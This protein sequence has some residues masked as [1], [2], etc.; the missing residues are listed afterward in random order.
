MICPECGAIAEYN[1]Y[2]GRTTCTR[3]AWESE[4]I[5]PFPS[6]TS[7]SVKKAKKD[8]YP[9]GERTFEAVKEG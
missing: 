5:K 7:E 1:A 9:I 6:I 2:Y 8:K 3:C 4:K